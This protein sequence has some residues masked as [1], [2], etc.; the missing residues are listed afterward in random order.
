MSDK[1]PIFDYD[2]N[3]FKDCEYT[4]EE[5][6]DLQRTLL[7]IQKS[8]NLF[9]DLKK[10]TVFNEKEIRVCLSMAFEKKVIKRK[11]NPLPVW[12]YT[13]VDDIKEKEIPLIDYSQTKHITENKYS[14]AQLLDLQK[15]MLTLQTSQ[16]LFKDL[17]K[18]SGFE[19][20]VV[21]ICLLR[22]L[23][24]KIIKKEKNSERTWIYFL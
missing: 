14:S 1:P 17:T 16:D 15:K 13:F 19:R 9:E 7:A 6:F 10:Q 5:L 23:D 3:Y 20:D 8:K 2:D 21:E 4:R 12:K 24:R 22:A 11:R 18:Y